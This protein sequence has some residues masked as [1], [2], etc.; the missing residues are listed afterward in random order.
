M[1]QTSMTTIFTLRRPVTTRSIWTTRTIQAAARSLCRQT[2]WTRIQV[3]PRRAHGSPSFRSGRISTRGGSAVEKQIATDET[4]NGLEGLSF[5]RLE[6]MS[7]G[8]TEQRQIVTTNGHFGAG[9]H[10]QS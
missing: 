4:L 5:N 3:R 1:M 7:G 10:R 2:V 8:Y 6:G 9:I